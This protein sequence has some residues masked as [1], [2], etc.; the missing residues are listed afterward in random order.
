MSIVFNQLADLHQDVTRNIVNV[1]PPSAAFSDLTSDL[2]EDASAIAQTAVMQAGHPHSNHA[3][4]LQFHHTAAIDYPFA[5][6]HFMAT[7]YSDGS[8]PVWYGALDL[9]TSIYETA[10]HMYQR[11]RLIEGNESVECIT[12]E[13]LV[14]DVYCEATLVDLSAVKN[15][16]VQDDYLQ[17]QVIGK[18]LYEQGFPGILAPS[19]RYSTGVNV[20]I[21]K[22]IVLFR[23]RV[24]CKLTYRLYPQMKKLDVQQAGRIIQTVSW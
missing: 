6:D 19:A 9:I 11:E 17:T 7:R 14:Y 20:N 18:K 22:P 2:G 12:R 3:L 8:F 13:R 5:T 10:H 24:K 4:D 21:F 1:L 16:L 15:E 23:P